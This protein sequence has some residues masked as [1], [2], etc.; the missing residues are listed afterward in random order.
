M[1]EAPQAA[2]TMVALSSGL[3]L[4]AF[5]GSG[6]AARRVLRAGRAGLQNDKIII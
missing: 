2:P 6:R 1:V 5:D 3:S 4:G